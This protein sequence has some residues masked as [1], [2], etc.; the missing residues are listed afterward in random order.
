MVAE[1]LIFGIRY[2]NQHYSTRHVDVASIAPH[3]DV[4]EIDIRWQG[5]GRASLRLM[6]PADVGFYSFLTPL[7]AILSVNK[8]IFE[9]RAF[10]PAGPF[11]TNKEIR[12]PSS[13][14]MN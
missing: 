4:I 1:N 11:L 10:L 2:Q 7:K 14:L 6:W 13:Q 8:L 9:L 3:P 12:G 5:R